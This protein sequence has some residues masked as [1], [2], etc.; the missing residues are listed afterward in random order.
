MH[1]PCV[2]TWRDFSTLCLLHQ[3][4]QVR[5]CKGCHQRTT[6]QNHSCQSKVDAD[7][8]PQASKVACSRQQPLD[9]DAQHDNEDTTDRLSV[10][11]RL[12]THRQ[13]DRRLS[14]TMCA[15]TVARLHALLKP[16]Q[17]KLCCASCHRDLV[18]G[19]L[20]QTVMIMAA[21]SSH[22]SG[23]TRSPAHRVASQSS[24]LS[25]EHRCHGCLCSTTNERTYGPGC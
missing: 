19:L 24:C 11:S 12:Q 8:N 23:F 16:S 14:W 1:W 25:V 22:A 3:V 15:V 4:N 18:T 2:Q 21:C 9:C 6:K 5:D 10:R 13:T 20:C 17:L 7:A